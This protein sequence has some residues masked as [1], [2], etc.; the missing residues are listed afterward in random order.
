MATGERFVMLG[1]AVA[2][3]RVQPG[4]AS[5]AP[6]PPVREYRLKRLMDF[7]LVN[8]A[9]LISA[10]LWL[11]ISAAIKLE[12]RGPV[13]YVQRRWGRAGKPFRVYKFRS[14]IADAD[15]KF[16]AVQANENDPR[17]TRVG[18]L[19]RATS[20]DELPQ[21][22]NIWRGQMSWVGPRALPIN[23]RQVNDTNA[24]TDDAVPGFALRC[25]VRPGLT[26]IAQIFAPRDVARYQKFRYDA[27]YVRRQSFSLD[28]RLILLSLWISVR[29]QWE[30]RGH[31]L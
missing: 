27:F 31:K 21:L 17:I 1:N 4:R 26:G 6:V 2:R 5:E 8:V 19:L 13:F 12:D 20:L 16:G 11:I 15:A 9:L 3:A 7:A 14:M 25:S 29:A 22:L 23:E 30:K 28:C 24:V 10:P 18:R